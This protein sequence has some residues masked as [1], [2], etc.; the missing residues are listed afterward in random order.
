MRRICWLFLVL[1]STAVAGAETLVIAHRGAS[2]Y[3]PEHTLPAVAMAH[4][5]GADYVEQDV[6]LTR[7]NKLV[8]LHD[9]TLDH[10]TD[11][12]RVFPGRSREDGH[13]YAI[14]FD[15]VEI[16]QLSVHERR[17]EEGRPVFAKRFPGDAQLLG[18]PTLAEEIEL[19][20]GM[21]RS[22]GRDVGLYVE[23]KEPAFHAQAGRDFP[24]I[25]LQELYSFGYRDADDNV[26][27]QCFDA[28]T[29]K[30]MRAAT[31]ILLVQL[32]EDEEL[33]AGRAIAIAGYADGV[34]PSIEE[35]M[36]AP[37]F[38]GA[39]QKAGL[40]VHAYTFRA[41]Q[42]PEG[43][44]SFAS[45]LDHFI[46]HVSVDGVFTDHPDLVRRYVDKIQ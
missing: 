13:F 23:L 5:M 29:L 14:D 41:D 20:Q 21:N 34:G 24:A 37:E 2:A 28:D 18:V 46:G 12:A 11:V 3:L 22:T 44:E 45:M 43:F 40:K 38:V 36:K 7:D 16:K 8:V 35:L 4:A 15:L 17:D 27:I 33:D 42:L 30:E 31:D 32:L 9:L 25:V 26:Y 1:I 39:A 6:V 19:I 10:T